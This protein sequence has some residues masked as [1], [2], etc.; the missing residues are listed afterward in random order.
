MTTVNKLKN[1]WLS[2]DTTNLDGS[3]NKVSLLNYGSTQLQDTIIKTK[4][5]INK[6]FDSVND[7]KLDVSGN[8]N[9]TGSL[10]Q[11]GS[12][13]TSGI[14]L[15]D[16]QTNANTFTNT[17]TFSG[18]LVLANKN[19]IQKV[20]TASGLSDSFTPLYWNFGDPQILHLSG[21]AIPI[22]L[23]LPNITNTSH[24]GT[25]FYIV[26]SAESTNGTAITISTNS[27]YTWMDETNSWVST[28]SYPSTSRVFAFVCI[29]LVSGW[30]LLF[31]QN[32]NTNAPYAWTGGHSFNTTL[33]TTTITSGFTNSNFI[34][35][36][37]ADISYQ[38]VSNMSNYQ[39]ISNNIIYVKNDANTNS[40]LLG[41]GSTS[42]TD[43]YNNFSAGALALNKCTTGYNNVGIGASALQFL[44]TGVE[45]F[46]LG[47]NAMKFTTSGN[48]NVV[49]GVNSGTNISSGS[50]NIF[51]GRYVGGGISTATDNVSIG[52]FSFLSGSGSGNTCIGAYSGQSLTTGTNNCIVGTQASGITTGSYN[53][54][55]G[56][57]STAGAGTYSN[58]T[59]IGYGSS[60]SG[61]NRII[62]GRSTE[63]TYA[64]GGLNIPVSTVFTLLGNIT[65]NGLSIAPGQLSFLTNV[66]SNK[67]PSSVISDISSYQTTAGMSAYQTTAGMSSYQTVAGMSSYQTTAGMSNYID[68][69]NSQTI[70]GIKTFSANPIFNANAILDTYL[71]TNITNTVSSANTFMNEYNAY[72]DFVSNIAGDTMNLI[73]CNLKLTT[74]YNLDITG[75]NIKANGT[76]ISDVKVSFL[77][78]VVSNQIPTSAI[79]N[80]GSGYQLISGMSSYQTVVGMSSYLTTATASSTYQLQSSMSSYLTTAA[81]SST[82]QL[83]NSSI[84]VS[85]ANVIAGVDA[86]INATSLDSTVAI[87]YRAAYQNITG[88]GTY[89]GTACGPARGYI[90]GSNGLW[91]YNGSAFS[92]TNPNNRMYVVSTNIPIA[93]GA[94]TTTGVTTIFDENNLSLLGSLGFQNSQLPSTIGTGRGGVY[95]YN[96][97]NP[98]S[99]APPKSNKFTFTASYTTST[100]ILNVTATNGVLNGGLIIYNSLIGLPP[101]VLYVL[102]YSASNPTNGGTGNYSFVTAYTANVASSAN[103][104]AWEPIY[105]PTS[106][107]NYTAN[108]SLINATAIGNNS[109]V[110]ESNST[111]IGNPYTS[112]VVGRQYLSKARPNVITGAYSISDDA[113][114]YTAYLI[115]FTANSTITLPLITPSMVGTEITFRRVSGTTTTTLSVISY[116]SLQAICSL[117][118]PTTFTTTASVIMTAGVYSSTILAC[119]LDISTSTTY[120]WVQI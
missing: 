18:D 59:A 110:L 86:D 103:W 106:T 54:L 14:S 104:V 21:Q 64:M 2:N 38:L 5:S 39:L 85:S 78:Q 49:V 20:F 77:N 41:S 65:A 10:Y 8:I 30:K 35:K 32:I 61:S 53:T 66:T 50:Q 40:F 4:L 31:S 79:T 67:I 57:L 23:I 88:S 75:A 70:G 27:P 96:T 73:N 1:I 119:K 52:Y 84:N 72:I 47:C 19:I 43:G 12:A 74:G 80:Y 55:I 58:S 6:N 101:Y 89:I 13:F 24:I 107:I 45:N 95:A 46:A 83:I 51:I 33:P 25:I 94:A 3:Y 62:L 93:V 76:T 29:S 9:F 105:Y 100:N 37:Y 91:S 11:N 36:G 7:Y 120:A 115:G 113:I 15:S 60:I 63:V 90:Y 108:T 112:T 98:A 26:L 92:F 116:G 111:Q 118:A 17:N 114:L 22:Y 71:S 48:F 28:R 87:G 44:T 16:V 34:T 81:A 117:S 42:I 97:G 69:V 109:I 82:Y 68:L 99:S 56:T 102:Q